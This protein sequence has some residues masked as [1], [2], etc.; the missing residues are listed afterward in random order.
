MIETSGG[1]DGH[2]RSGSRGGNRTLPSLPVPAIDPHAV[3]A[4]SL[5]AL[6]KRHKPSLFGGRLKPLG[7]K[8]LAGNRSAAS[9]HS[10]KPGTRRGPSLGARRAVALEGLGAGHL[11]PDGSLTSLPGVSSAAPR[12]A[13]VDGPHAEEGKDAHWHDSEGQAEGQGSP[14]ESKRTEADAGALAGSRRLSGPLVR[15]GR[16]SAAAGGRAASGA[17]AGSS[18]WRGSF[19]QALGVGPEDVAQLEAGNF[20]YLRRKRGNGAGA[21]DLEVCSAQEVDPSDYMTLSEGGVTRFVGDSSDFTP[22]SAWDREFS[23]F[24]R[25][26]QVRF[27]RLYRRWKA[28]TGWKQMLQRRKAF[29]AS[30][31]VSKSLFVL[32]PVLRT[33]VG[34]VRRLCDAVRKWRLFHVDP[35]RVYSIAEFTATQAAKR[36]AVATW[37]AEFS[38]DV[39]LLVRG[40]CDEVLHAFLEKQE[41]NGDTKM[42][43]MERASLRGQCGSLTRFIRVCDFT[44]QDALLNLALDSAASLL[45]AVRPTGESAPRR[46]IRRDLNKK[47]QDLAPPKK[48][49]TSGLDEEDDEDA[50]EPGDEAGKT[51]Q[52]TTT[53]ESLAGSGLDGLVQPR[54]PLLEMLVR[55][56]EVEPES[57]DLEAG[58]GAVSVGEDEEMPA[59]HDGPGST[60]AADA[61]T[62][63]G[64]SESKQSGDD[65]DVDEEPEHPQEQLPSV[66]IELEPSAE[67]VKSRLSA[68]LARAMAVATAMPPML[69]HEDLRPYTSAAGED[70][71]GGP[72]A[73]GAG[74]DDDDG[75]DG[76]AAGDSLQ[77][78]VATHPEFRRI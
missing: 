53:L 6:P 10:S 45:Q 43:F 33:C 64:A 68:L 12:A 2:A 36:R 42:T 23:M 32:D 76:G 40:A 20:V 8:T 21:Y 70:E 38:D 27:F 46:I 60:K 73:G 65:G 13:P 18:S 34:R 67:T 30:R 1:S 74:D 3:S 62:G 26:L 39:R 9:L 14:S 63:A 55:L 4:A 78:R 50:S 22:L 41:I 48:K 16:R 29:D 47:E 69:Q 11:A 59:G 17:G 44:V 54:V 61:G 35:L 75:G 77:A 37:L 51:G 56:D 71:A 31:A 72:A 7:G 15:G 24:Q 57:S 49:G 5:P 58:L 28:F 25:I 66:R 19:L 52:S